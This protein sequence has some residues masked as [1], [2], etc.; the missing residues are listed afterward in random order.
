MLPC[1]DQILQLNGA[2]IL[3][4]PVNH[5]NRGNVIIFPGL[6][7]QLP[8]G[9]PDSQVVVDQDKIGGHVATDLI[10]VVGQQKLYVLAGLFVQHSQNF[11]FCIVVHFLQNV[12]RVVGIHLGN[13][14]RLLL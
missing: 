2:V 14:F 6:L 9:L 7:H 4:R 1:D 12:H 8:H 3:L 5:I 13:D 11:T 10:F